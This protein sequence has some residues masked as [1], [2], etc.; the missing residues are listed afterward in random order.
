M[1][2]KSIVF[3]AL[4]NDT[5]ITNL[6]PV[7][8]INQQWFNRDIGLPQITIFRINETGAIHG[9]NKMLNRQTPMQIDIW[10]GTNVSP[11]PIETEVKR[12]LDTIG[13]NPL[14]VAESN[15][16]DEPIYRITIQTNINEV[17]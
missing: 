14:V 3:Q 10:V 12:I 2:A 11:T 15:E 5:G 13:T 7:D 4:I 16:L 6:V 9:D 1:S 8:N 17:T